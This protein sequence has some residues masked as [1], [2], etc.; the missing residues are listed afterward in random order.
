MAVVVAVVD[1]QTVAVA[2]V[3]HQIEYCQVAVDTE[4]ASQAAAAAAAGRQTEY[5]ADPPVESASAAVHHSQAGPQSRD[6][7]C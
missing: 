4:A 7:P 2:V 6:R 1:F 5:S 3:G